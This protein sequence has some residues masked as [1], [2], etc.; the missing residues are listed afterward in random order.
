MDIMLAT[1]I[2]IG[3]ILFFVVILNT[4]QGDKTDELKGDAA[5][6]IE[7][8]TSEESEFLI[9]D[10]NKINLTKLDTLFDG[11]Y[12]EIKRKLRV[13]NEFCLYF[14]DEEGKIIYIKETYTGIGS[15]TINV[16]DIACG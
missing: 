11:D 4:T 12:S 6:V 16:S 14:E 5:R 15:G 9:L 3:T 2:F 13:K 7:G 1:I 8:I 10:G